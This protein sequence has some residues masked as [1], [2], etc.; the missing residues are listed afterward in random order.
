M[1]ERTSVRDS[2]TINPKRGWK[3]VRYCAG[4]GKETQTK[5]AL[6]LNE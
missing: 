5:K 4:A 2:K 6:S 1:N 3:P